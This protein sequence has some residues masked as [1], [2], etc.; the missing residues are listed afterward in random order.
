MGLG[1][2][3]WEKLVRSGGYIQNPSMRDYLL[4]GIKDAPATMRTIFV[5]NDD[6]TGPFGAKGVA[7]ASLIPVPAA[8]AAA[9]NDA[10]GIR[11]D[12]LPMDAES[13]F[14]LMQAAAHASE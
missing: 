7:E 12:K 4:P 3:L 5:D 10:V 6:E 14:H 8:I 13:V 11:P 9:L 2:A 1:M